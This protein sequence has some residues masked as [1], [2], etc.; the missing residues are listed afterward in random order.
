MSDLSD[1][2]RDSFDNHAKMACREGNLRVLRESGYLL[3]EDND[4]LRL[5]CD[6]CELMGTT[7]WLTLDLLERAGV[8]AP[9]GFVGVDLDRVRIDNFRQRRPDLKWIA[10]NLYEHLDR[11]ELANVGILNLDEYGEVGSQNALVD[12]SL[13][14]ALVKAGLEKFDEFALFWNQ[15]L[16]AVVRR[17]GDRGQRLR[18]HAEMVCE[19]LKGCLPRRD[20]TSSML[21]PEGGEDKI[22]S[23]FIGT[24]GA[25]EIYRGANR[26]HRMANLRIILR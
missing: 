18:H 5:R 13:I 4:R 3:W 2:N 12:F 24:L 17:R 20:L 7:G 8:L 19:A 22:N 1:R 9:G 21:L 26:G 14:R 16:D 25:F 23:G 15:D 6:W 11:V 10:G